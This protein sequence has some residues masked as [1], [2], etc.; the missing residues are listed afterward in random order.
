MKR[1]NFFCSPLALLFGK[2]NN[3]E[4]TIPET[5]IESSPII[6]GRVQEF[7]NMGSFTTAVQQDY[8]TYDREWGIGTNLATGDDTFSPVKGNLRYN[9]RIPR[10]RKISLK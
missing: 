5:N 8:V 4:I 6:R 2:S 9:V 3:P 7:N 10:K 1:R